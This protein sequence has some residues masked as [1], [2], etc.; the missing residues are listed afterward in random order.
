M[1]PFLRRHYHTENVCFHLLQFPK[2]A[3]RIGL[4]S[5]LVK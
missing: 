2:D 4:M 1:K 3:I 5:L